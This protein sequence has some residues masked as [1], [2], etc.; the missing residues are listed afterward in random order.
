MDFLCLAGRVA[1]AVWLLGGAGCSLALKTDGE[2][3]TVDADCAARGSAFAGTVCTPNNVCKQCNV[4]ADCTSRGAGDVC[5]NNVCTAKVVQDP[6]WGCIGNVQPLPTGSMTQVKVQLVDLLSMQPVSSGLTVKL[7]AKLDPTCAHALATPAPDAMGFVSVMVASNFDGY[8]DVTDASSTMYLHS[9]IFIDPA[10]V[11]QNST[12]LLVSS[13]EEMSLA[14]FA[15][16]TVDPTMGLLLVPAVDCTGA[17]TAGAS[18]SAAP[19]GNETPFYVI[20][21]TPSKTATETDTSGNMGFVNAVPGDVTV[22]GTLG[23]GGKEFGKVT[24]IV[25][26]GSL[27]YQIIRPTPT[28]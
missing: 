15:Q 20:G 11:A 18:V 4:D 2:Q 16:V 7:C 28:P 8:L 6:K 24:T 17:R 3:C 13:G 22:T 12:I 14:Q 1:L 21:N 5:T 25:A 10:V 19:A 27:T 23:P 9:L 26:A